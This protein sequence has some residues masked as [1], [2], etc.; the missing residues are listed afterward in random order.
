MRGLRNANPRA[1]NKAMRDLLQI[2]AHSKAAG[3]HLRRAEQLSKDRYQH[4]LANDFMAAHGAL[5]PAEAKA[6][7]TYG[8]AARGA[9]RR[10][11]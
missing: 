1:Q 3:Y 6:E 9:V 4:D 10:A 7:R 11:R 5:A 8:A 2:L